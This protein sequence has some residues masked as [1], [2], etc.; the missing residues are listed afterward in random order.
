LKPAADGGSVLE[1]TDGAD[2][3]DRN[4][5]TL[6]E[7]RGAVAIELQGLRQRRARVRFH[8]ILSRGR[9]RELG[10]RAHT[11]RVMVAAAEQR[12]AGRR[13][14]RGRVESCVLETA[15]GELLEV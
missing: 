6:A 7:L 8:R 13:A 3:S 1:G 4:F 2:L 10:D 11:H 9:G 12:R 15:G 14:E 5:V